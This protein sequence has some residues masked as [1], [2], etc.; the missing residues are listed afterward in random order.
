M[1]Y[2]SLAV[3]LAAG[4]ALSGCDGNQLDAVAN[5]GSS[6]TSTTQTLNCSGPN[7]GSTTGG[8]TGTG[9][10]PTP[11]PS[12]NTG[13]TSTI[14]TGDTTLALDNGLLVSRANNTAVSTLTQ[15][16][17]P[18]STA[19]LA[20][21]TNTSSNA[22]WPTTKVLD[23][24]VA[25]TTKGSGI[26][27]TYKEYHK[28]TK[29]PGAASTQDEEL[30]VWRW[31]A[32]TGS[33]YATQ[34][35]DVTTGG[36][37]AT[38]QAW[39]FGGNY[40]TAAQMPTSGSATYSGQ[41]T[42]VATTS[43]FINPTNPPV[44]VQTLDRNNIWSVTGDTALTANFG[45]NGTV[46]GTLTPNAWKAWQTLGGASGFATATNPNTIP[47]GGIAYNNPANW[48]GAA[49]GGFMDQQIQLA[50]T[51]TTNASTTAGTHANVIKGTAQYDPTSN[52]INTSSNSFF[53]AGFFGNNA[54]NITGV[55]AMDAQTLQPIGGS[56]A[57]ND[58]RRGYVSM[59]GIFNACKTGPVC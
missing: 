55:F 2:A 1:R 41:F 25:G 52:W 20:I 4:T 51:I 7:S 9:T 27:G 19:Q 8:G 12:P 31:N 33:S 28:I 17:L 10:T 22:I 47:D 14:T 6:C 5:L 57:I 53:E 32:G 3:L 58:D 50:G 39:S 30:Q 26:G 16:T 13:N 15:S 21:N 56:T 43:N 11:T 36:N 49:Q 44:G 23:E 38:H 46:T 40:T 42:S 37:P 59:T 35:R 18:T 45:S 54:D 29:A 24:Y 48:F 34:Y